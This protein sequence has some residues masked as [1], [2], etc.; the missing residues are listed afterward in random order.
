MEVPN[1]GEG[2]DKLVCSEDGHFMKLLGLAFLFSTLAE[3]SPH[4]SRNQLLFLHI[5]YFSL[6]VCTISNRLYP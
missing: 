2:I 1:K 5:S 3:A 4:F 6:R